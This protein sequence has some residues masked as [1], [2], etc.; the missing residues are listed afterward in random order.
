MSDTQNSLILQ[1]QKQ[2]RDNKPKKPTT[3]IPTIQTPKQGI[4]EQKNKNMNTNTIMTSTKRNRYQILLR[5]LPGLP[6]HL[7]HNHT[8]PH[9]Q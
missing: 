1:H 2:T 6:P 5:P 9:L 4:R 7:L 8:P 3:Y